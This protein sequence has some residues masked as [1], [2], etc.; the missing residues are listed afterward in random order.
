MDPMKLYSCLNGVC[1]AYFSIVSVFVTSGLM[2][3]LSTIYPN[4]STCIHSNLHLSIET[5]KF[6]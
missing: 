1:K 6:S 4:H 3:S 5:A 2:P